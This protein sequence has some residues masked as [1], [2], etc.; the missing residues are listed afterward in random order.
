MTIVVLAKKYHY[1][2]KKKENEEKT[3]LGKTNKQLI[4]SEALTDFCG[5][6]IPTW[7]IQI[8]TMKCFNKWIQKFSVKYGSYC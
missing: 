8:A 3:S 5:T 7:L 6:N 4:R 1:I 2:E